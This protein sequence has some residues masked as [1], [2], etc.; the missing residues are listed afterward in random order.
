MFLFLKEAGEFSDYADC[1]TRTQEIMML[2]VAHVR[3]PELLIGL[4]RTRVALNPWSSDSSQSDLASSNLVGFVRIVS[5]LRQHLGVSRITTHG[6][7]PELDSLVDALVH[8]LDRRYRSITS[9]LAEERDFQ[10]QYHEAIADKSIWRRDGDV[11]EFEAEFEAGAQAGAEAEA[12]DTVGGLGLGLSETPAA[13]SDSNLDLDLSV[14]SVGWTSLLD[15]V[16]RDTVLTRM[17]QHASGLAPGGLP[18]LDDVALPPLSAAS[19]GAATAASLSVADPAACSSTAYSQVEASTDTLGADSIEAVRAAELWT[20]T[21]A[22]VERWVPRASA[23]IQPPAVVGW[24]DPAGSAALPSL[25]AAVDGWGGPAGATAQPSLL[26]NTLASGKRKRNA[27]AY[28]EQE[29]DIAEHPVKR[30][31]HPAKS[32]GKAPAKPD[33]KNSAKVPAKSPVKRPPTASHKYD[34]GTVEPLMEW[35]VAHASDPYPS[36]AGKAE[37]MKKTQLSS[38]QVQNW[39]TNVRKRHWVPLKNGTRKP[40]TFMDFLLVNIHS[41]ESPEGQSGK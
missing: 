17:P 12:E 40:R 36:E 16:L 6:E 4:Y 3:M 5:R 34:K 10:R 13:W 33:A 19:A 1:H 9:L 31:V 11:F 25:P 2:V 29:A 8:E 7:Q 24:D 27:P 18:S 35:F 15:Q 21:P 38:K 32:K 22:E 14:Q 37:L 30:A 41:A 39:F 20:S 23:H 26:A 28:L